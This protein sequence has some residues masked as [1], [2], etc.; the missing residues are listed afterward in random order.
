MK[1]LVLAAIVG[2]LLPS[3]AS[4]ALPAPSPI[5]SASKWAVDYSENACTL[6]RQFGDQAMPMTLGVIPMPMSKSAR[7]VLITPDRLKAIPY[8]EGMIEFDG[9]SAPI[10]TH[11]QVV[12]GVKVGSVMETW[13]EGDLLGGIEKSVV[14][15][16]R[17]QGATVSLRIGASSRAVAALRSC[18]A[19]LLARWG[20][21]KA[22]QAQVVTPPDGSVIGMFRDNDYPS[23]ALQA[24]QQGEVV[25]RYWV[26]TNGRLSDCKVVKSSGSASLDSAT[27]GIVTERA[28]LKPARNAEGLPVR[29]LTSSSIIWRIPTQ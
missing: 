29:S 27:C 21:D 12:P 4:V 22:A 14:L 23:D 10:K 24:N 3:A 25:M 1:S 13:I 15:T 16:F 11:F 17:P 5:P 8:S 7:V 19:D 20:M 2:L 26:E 6:S 28:R 18:G 9:S